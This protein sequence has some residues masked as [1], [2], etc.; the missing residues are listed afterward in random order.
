MGRLLDRIRNR[1]AVPAVRELIGQGLNIVDQVATDKDK[2]NELKYTLAKAQAQLMMSG[3][4][5]SITKYTICFLISLV[6]G[7]GTWVFV[8]GGDMQ[9]FRDYALAVVPIISILTGSYITGT[10]FKRSR[11]SKDE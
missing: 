1:P 3:P 2:L 4:G 6:V 10:S 11:W 9:T 7:S 8:T 5:S